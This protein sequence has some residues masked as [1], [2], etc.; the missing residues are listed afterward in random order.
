M[1]HTPTLVIGSGIE[2]GAPDTIVLDFSDLSES[3]L[4]CM[5]ETDGHAGPCRLQSA[6][7]APGTLVRTRAGRFDVVPS[8]TGVVLNAVTGADGAVTLAVWFWALG[9]PVIG[10]TLLPVKGGEVQPLAT[11]LDMLPAPTRAAMVRRVT[12]AVEEGGT[13]ALAASVL[14]PLLGL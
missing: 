6:P 1:E 13:P 10:A 4:A 11:T 14:A 12:E 2:A 9:A 5:V 7:I 3:C 8:R